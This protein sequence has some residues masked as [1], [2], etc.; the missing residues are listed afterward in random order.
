MLKS[1]DVSGNP[2]SE[3]HEHSVRFFCFICRR[4][5]VREQ[6]SEAESSPEK[7]FFYNSGFPSFF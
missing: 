1:G 3:Q 4:L 6:V 5:D 2:N 7:H